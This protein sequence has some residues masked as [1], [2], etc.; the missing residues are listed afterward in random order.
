MIVFDKDVADQYKRVAVAFDGPYKDMVNKNY[1]KHVMQGP[2]YNDEKSPAALAA[3][4]SLS[5]AT[6]SRYKGLVKMRSVCDNCELK[7]TD[8]CKC[9]FQGQR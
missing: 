1:P 7:G 6:P 9:P 2:W 3:G 5:E 8:Q 4:H